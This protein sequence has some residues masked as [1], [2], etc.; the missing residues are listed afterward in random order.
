V[1]QYKNLVD[2]PTSSLGK[3]TKRK[4]QKKPIVNPP[5]PSLSFDP[6]PKKPQELIQQE[7]PIIPTNRRGANQF[8]KRPF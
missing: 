2:I 7:F 6:T 3:K 1:E 5:M 8:G 4:Y